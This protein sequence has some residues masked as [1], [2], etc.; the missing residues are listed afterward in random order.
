MRI[1]A[2]YVIQPD[3]KEAVA[4]WTMDTDTRTV[5]VHQTAKE[6]RLRDGDSVLCLINNHYDD[7]GPTLNTHTISA[8]VVRVLR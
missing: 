8:D 3:G 2:I 4:E 6:F 7:V 5:V 1:P